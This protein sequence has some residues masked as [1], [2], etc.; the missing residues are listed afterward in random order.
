MGHSI[1]GYLR[2]MDVGA[3]ARDL[4]PPADIPLE[5]P[6]DSTAGLLRE[7]VAPIVLSVLML[8]LGLFR[9]S[10]KSLWQD[11]GFTWSSA[12]LSAGNL[13]HHLLNT[14]ATGGLY[15]VFQH[16]WIQLGTGLWRL[17]LPSVIF[18]TA[19]VPVLWVLTRRLCGDARTATFAAALLVVNATFLDHVQEAR[20]YPLVVLLACTSMYWFVREM[21]QPSRWN[22]GW[23]ALTTILLVLAH[24]VAGLVFI[25]QLASL[26]VARP[27]RHRRRQVVVGASM[28]AVVV[29][30]FGLLAASQPLRGP[31]N[32]PSLRFFYNTIRFLTGGGNLLVAAEAL[33]AAGALVLMV[34]AF[35][36]RGR[37]DAAWRLAL[38][39]FWFGLS[40]VLFFLYCQMATGFQ[41]RYLL[42]FLPGLFILVSVGITGIPSRALRV[43]AVLVVLGLAA[44][45]VWHWYD[46]VPREGWNVIASVLRHDQRPGDVIVFDV[47]LSRIPV[48]YYLRDQPRTQRDVTPAWPGGRAWVSGFRTGDY[49]FAAIPTAVMARIAAHHD[50]IWVVDVG[51]LDQKTGKALRILRTT[52]RRELDIAVDGSPSLQLYVRK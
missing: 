2:L 51:A 16:F 46:G 15:L 5:E 11:E 39:A 3:G 21:E 13:I 23:W 19:A 34:R 1:P 28:I 26:M 44:R 17:R 12:T 24:V 22:R 31:V 18:A 14:E 49:R 25:A 48:A 35:R 27:D 45:G 47:D 52:H 4:L 29:V 32:T 33:A 40:S 20:T 50:R 41:Q 10:A 43:V 42:A 37:S 36:M 38:P 8:G 9:L 6:Q 30:P 7:Y